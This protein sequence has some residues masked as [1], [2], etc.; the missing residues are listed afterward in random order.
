MIRLFIPFIFLAFSIGHAQPS[1]PI[2]GSHLPPL[3]LDLL[4]YL[5][6]Q[7]GIASNDYALKKCKKDEPPVWAPATCPIAAYILTHAKAATAEAI[8]A[9]PARLV[10]FGETHTSQGSKHFLRGLLPE[11]KARG[12][13]VLAME[14]F[15]ISQQTVLDDFFAGRAPLDDVRVALQSAW[16]HE[17]Q[18]YLDLIAAAKT[19]GIRVLAL[20][21]RSR[22]P[23]YPQVENIRLRD[24]IM[25]Q[26]LADALTAD[27]S[28]KIF[29]F[30]GALHAQCSLS[31]SQAILSQSEVF[32][33][34]TQI[35]TRCLTFR[36]H[37]RG[38]STVT[39]LYYRNGSSQP[40][41]LPLD[42]NVAYSD[43]YILLPKNYASE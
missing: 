12:Y 3:D 31:R 19:L 28:L 22:V 26:R 25:A 2:I 24:L 13:S 1:S 43:G 40:A 23:N 18:G 17:S 38:K 5:G 14:M 35:P 42:R 32:T 15:N 4:L 6:T 9:S 34:T 41:F 20:D 29:A 21:D 33:R 30:T 7:S 37:M 11:L 16:S 39:D 10:Y 27:P 36:E 8:L